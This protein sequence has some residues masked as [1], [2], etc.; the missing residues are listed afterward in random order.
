MSFCK[1]THTRSIPVSRRNGFSLVEMLVAVTVMALLGTILLQ[2]FLSADRMNRAAASLDKAMNLSVDAVERLKAENP[3]TL[4]TKEKLSAVFPD[5]NITDYGDGWRVRLLFDKDWQAF[6]M[7]RSDWPAH[8]LQMEL[9]PDPETGSRTTSVHVLVADSGEP[10]KGAGFADNTEI[11][12]FSLD[13][14]LSS[15][16]EGKGVEP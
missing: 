5:A 4:W 3:A 10:G 14:E 15:V 1:D 12:L 16:C 8:Y 11:S 9:A 2:V 7:V 6:S 13:A